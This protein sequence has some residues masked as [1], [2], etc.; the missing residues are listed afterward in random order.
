ML[1]YLRVSERL[2][3]ITPLDETR[4]RDINYRQLNERAD[5]IGLGLR[6]AVLAPGERVAL[7]ARNSIDYIASLLGIM[8][9]GLVAVP[10]NFRFPT[11]TIGHI[12]N[13]SGSRLLL[14]DEDQLARVESD[15]PRVAFGSELERFQRAGVRACPLRPRRRRSGPAAVHLRLDRH[16][17]GGVLD[18]RQ[19]PLGGRDPPCPPG[20]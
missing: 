8:R 10:I 15:L 5:A 19:P 7:L 20:A 6:Q 11:D 18:P 12:L 3:F 4:Q 17:E 9:A 1:F 2:A 13:D 16:P 14:G